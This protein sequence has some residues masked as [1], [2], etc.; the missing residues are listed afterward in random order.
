[1][2]LSESCTPEYRGFLVSMPIVF[3]ELG[4]CLVYGAGGFLEWRSLAWVGLALVPP[5]ALLVYTQ[6]ESYVFLLTKNRTK[7]AERNLKL[8]RG[9]W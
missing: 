4:F 3:I 1:M 8:L 7:E 9:T 6:P 5:S 2:Y